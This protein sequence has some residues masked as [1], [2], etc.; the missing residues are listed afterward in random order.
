MIKNENRQMNPY[1]SIC[2]F[3]RSL[4]FLSPLPQEPLQLAP[5]PDFLSPDPHPL[6]LSTLLQPL[7]L[8]LVLQPLERIP[9]EKPLK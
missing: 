8:S 1:I 3:P 6:G 2:R 9:S 4:Y 5:H 7:V